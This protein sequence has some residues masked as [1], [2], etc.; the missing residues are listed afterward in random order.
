MIYLTKI[1]QIFPFPL[2]FLELSRFVNIINGK[3]AG[4]FHRKI[5]TKLIII[6]KYCAKIRRILKVCP[7][8]CLNFI[9]M[10][11]HCFFY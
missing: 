7:F 2:L 11:R 1:E 5:D 8:K 6:A 10:H 4:A 3:N 9:V